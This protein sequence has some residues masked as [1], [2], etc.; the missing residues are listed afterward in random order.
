MK[1][2]QSQLRPR[3]EPQKAYDDWLANAAELD[4]LET[5]THKASTSGEDNLETDT[6]NGSEDS[7]ITV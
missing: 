6:V 2:G 1:A 7:N 4:K 3:A 5:L